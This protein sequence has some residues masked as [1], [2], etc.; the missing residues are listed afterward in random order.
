[1]SLASPEH[2]HQENKSPNVLHPK[3]SVFQKND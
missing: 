1:L 3:H 2:Y